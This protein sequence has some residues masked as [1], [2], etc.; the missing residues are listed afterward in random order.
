MSPMCWMAFPR[1]ICFAHLGKFGD[2][3]IMLPGFKAISD[4]TS[5]PPVVIVSYE[6]AS[7]FDGVSYARAW[8]VQMRWW[9]D[10]P[11]AVQLGEEKFGHCIVPKFWDAHRKEPFKLNGEPTVT[12]TI[13]GVKTV[14]PAGQWDSYALAQWRYSGFTSSQYFD[15][16]V[17]FDRRSEDREIALRRRLFRTSKPKLLVNLSQSGTSP[18][19][20]IQEVVSVID[21]NVFELVDLSQVRAHRIYDLL[22]LFDCAAGLITSDT[23]TLHLAAASKSPYIALV[24]DGAAGSV[25]RGNCLLTVRYSEVRRRRLDIKATVASFHDHG[26]DSHHLQSQ[27]AR[28]G[29]ATN[30]ERVAVA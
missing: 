1:P 19:T 23:A 22:G 17:V 24:N 25:A 13:H 15:L 27:P 7:I 16:P 3:L 9:K 11:A 8:P 14:V 29:R 6:F 18:F 4:A 2:I 10:A 20:F 30:H 5:V 28:S 21:G 12:I 26:A